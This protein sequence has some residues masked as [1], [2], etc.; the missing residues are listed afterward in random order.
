MMQSAFLQ[1]IGYEGQS[2]TFDDLPVLLKK[3]AYTF[4]FENRS[5]LNK[6]S[7]ALNQE[8]LKE[9]LLEGGRGGLCYDLNPLLY[10]VLKEAGLAVQLV[11]GTVY[12]KEA[13]IWAIDGTHV[14]M[15]L[16]HQ[17][18]RY[19]IDA[20]F[21]VNL[22]LQP[23][24]FT[25]EWVEGASIRFRVKEEE[26]EKG[27]HL[28][29]LDRGEGAETGYAFTLEE[30]SEPTLVQMREEIYENEASPFNKRPLASKLTPTGRVIV[31]EDH[32]TIHEHE[33]VSKKP[34][35]L[36]FEEYVKTLLP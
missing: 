4:P 12:N 19:L 3:M 11:Q 20:G 21:G 33:E 36:P 27:T 22:P 6:Q 25:E 1:K 14:A 2:I 17:N 13:G 26:T 10:Y 8:G 34:L 15:T 28:L 30:V 9:H 16:N 29:Q 5:V 23:V 32:V 7:Y 18:E 35:S 31:T 24:P